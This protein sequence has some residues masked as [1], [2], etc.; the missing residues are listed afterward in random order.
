M[1]IEKRFIPALTLILMGVPYGAAVAD[2]F[3]KEAVIVGGYSD[4]DQWVGDRGSLKLWDS[5]T[6]RHF[7]MSMVIS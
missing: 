6:F 7:P 1:V 3:Y 2:G 5:N 4:N